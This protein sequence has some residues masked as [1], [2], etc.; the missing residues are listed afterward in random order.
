[1]HETSLE[2]FEAQFRMNLRP[3]Y[4]VTKAALPRM[5]SGGAVVCVA[6]RAAVRPFSGAAGYIQAAVIALAQAVAVEY[7]DDIRCNA[8]LPSIIDTPA[9]RRSQPGADPARSV[10]P[11][12]IAA[13]IAFLCDDASST[14]SGAAIPVYG[15][16]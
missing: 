6:S 11:E 8:V 14:V 16:A 2:D 7:R 5:T 4:L 3:T 13:V 9:N 10:S 1:M 15:R 12:Q